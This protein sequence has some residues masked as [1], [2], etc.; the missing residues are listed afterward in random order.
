MKTL[1]MMPEYIEWVTQGK[2]WATTRLKYNGDTEY[3]LI[4]GSYY[5]PIKSG[6]KIRVT[7]VYDWYPNLA[8]PIEREREIVKAEN[9]KDIREL[10]AVL[11]KLNKG[12]IDTAT[13]LHTIFFEV[14]K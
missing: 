9:F 14:V 11:M 1:R 5:K 13:P 12:K 8:L 7:S 3:E 10:I 4:S 2:K 6:V